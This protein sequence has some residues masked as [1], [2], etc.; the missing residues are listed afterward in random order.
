MTAV[1]KLN[2]MT[3]E[4]KPIER[5]RSL[6]NDAYQHI[7]ASILSN[8]LEPG[9]QLK[10]EWLAAQLQISPTPVREALAKLEQ[11]KLVTVIPHRG[12]FVA[13]ITP[14]DVRHI[15]EVRRELEGLAIMLAIPNIPP[16]ELEALEQFFKIAERQMEQGHY[17]EY[18]K[19]DTNLHGLILKNISNQWLLQMLQELN[20]HVKR[21]RAFS[22]THSGPHIRRSLAEH[23]AI[24][25]AMKKR[26]LQKAKTLME[27]HVQK[28]GERIA[29]IVELVT[30]GQ[31]TALERA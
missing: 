13:E 1:S 9:Q 6:T 25:E 21:I 15:Y 14:E 29:K 16:A 28:S 3:L 30:G 12:K 26:D 31:T 11:E 2:E 7:K 5:S 24:L 27:E 8:K 19:S 23:Y 18:F 20:D 22:I 4:L 10:E 17:D